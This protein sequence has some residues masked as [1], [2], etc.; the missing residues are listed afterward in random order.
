MV[1]F[2]HQPQT[3]IK[4]VEQTS[5]Q[6]SIYQPPSYINTPSFPTNSMTYVGKYDPPQNSF[7][8]RSLSQPAHFIYNQANNISINQQTATRVSETTSQHQILGG[9]TNLNHQIHSIGGGNSNQN[10]TFSHN[11]SNNML[12]PFSKNVNLT[13]SGYVYRNEL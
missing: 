9:N 11:S 3:E 7:D 2:N 5:Q 8:I 13:T 12:Y 1:K 4:I 10:N 6:S